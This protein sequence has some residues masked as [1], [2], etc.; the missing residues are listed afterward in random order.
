MK[1]TL[2]VRF[3]RPGKKHFDCKPAAYE[4]SCRVNPVGPSTK[5]R[6]PKN[7]CVWTLAL[8]LRSRARQGRHLYLY[9]GEWYGG[10]SEADSN[11]GQSNWPRRCYKRPLNV[12]VPPSGPFARRCRGLNQS[13]SA[14]AR[15]ESDIPDNGPTTINTFLFTMQ[16]G[17]PPLSAMPC[18]YPKNKY[19]CNK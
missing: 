17:G 1:S 11:G 13:G 14:T 18:C 8:H 15:H 3:N 2:M 4:R 16:E 12:S 10:R 5:T 6:K 19:K 7:S 9:G